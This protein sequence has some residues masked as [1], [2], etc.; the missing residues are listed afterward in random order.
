MN[1]EPDMMEWVAGGIAFEFSVEKANLKKAASVPFA[2]ADPGKYG[3]G[4]FSPD[5]CD[6]RSI[7]CVY[8]KYPEFDNLASAYNTT[9][10]STIK[11]ES[12]TPRRTK[13]MEC[14]ADFPSVALP[15]LPDVPILECS[16]E[17]PVCNGGKSNVKK[18]DTRD[19]T[20]TAA[21]AV[22]I[23]KSGRNG[24]SGDNDSDRNSASTTTTTLLLSILVTVCVVVFA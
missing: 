11:L 15:P 5:N 1:T 6:H 7:P 20:T 24:G 10:A 16:V 19:D 17:E 22:G 18:G 21:P 13:A 3:I 2:K 4:Y 14:P 9:P 23:G 8:N 12:F